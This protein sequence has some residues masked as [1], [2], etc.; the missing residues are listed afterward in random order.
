M[1]RRE[2]RKEKKYNKWDKKVRGLRN[3]LRKEENN[4]I[5][6]DVINYSDA[7]GLTR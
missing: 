3:N 4:T 2:R 7:G 6:S 5:A 1:N